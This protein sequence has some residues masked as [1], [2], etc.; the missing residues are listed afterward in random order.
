MNK[1]LLSALLWCA[2]A[3]PVCG[4]ENVA[5]QARIPA[6]FRAH[7]T[8]AAQL[9]VERYEWGT[10]QWLCNATLSPGSQQTL[11][12]AVILPGRQNPLHYHPNCEEVLHVLSG[13]GRHSYDGRWVDLTPGMT[14]RIP[15]GVKHNLVNTGG[16]PLRTL[17]AFSTGDR[18]TVFLETQPTRPN[19]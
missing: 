8:D 7:V 10:L 4:S 1:Y 15:A 14:I 6:E 13:Q 19:P 9:P 16:E 17:I 2:S 12:L 18:Q 11:G 5:A 3:P